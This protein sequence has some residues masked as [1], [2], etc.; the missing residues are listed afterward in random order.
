MTPLLDTTLPV[1]HIG[2]MGKH[3]KTLEQIKRLMGGLHWTKVE[4]LL[5][6][7]KAKVYEGSGSTVT[8]VLME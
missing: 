8:F 7:Y 5:K 3:Q 1:S 2:T 6:S 4:Q